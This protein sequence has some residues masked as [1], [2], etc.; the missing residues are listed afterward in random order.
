MKKTS[1][2]RVGGKSPTLNAF[3]TVPLKRLYFNKFK[4][5]ITIVSPVD[6]HKLYLYNTYTHSTVVRSKTVIAEEK[7]L[8]KEVE[9][10]KNLISN[11]LIELYGEPSKTP[12]RIYGK[13]K[14]FMYGRRHSLY[15]KDQRDA[16]IVIKYLQPYIIEVEKPIN[17]KHVSICEEEIFLERQ[18]KRRL[19]FN[20]YRYKALYHS[21][22]AINLKE[23][24]NELNQLFSGRS[25]DMFEVRHNSCSLSIC[26]NNKEDL[27]MLKLAAPEISIFY[28]AILISELKENENE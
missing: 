2:K 6:T 5:K 14:S 12:Y 13:I 20:N 15:L 19:F 25:S 24:E 10:Y 21:Y 8:K 26:F 23:K 1:K 17:E 22:S 7:K 3:I 18:I 11:L 9:K 27:L 4:Y 16:E 28:E